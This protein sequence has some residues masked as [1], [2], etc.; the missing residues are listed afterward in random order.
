MPP[1]EQQF[2]EFLLSLDQV[3]KQLAEFMLGQYLAHDFSGDSEDDEATLNPQV[4]LDV[5]DGVPRVT[6]NHTIT[7]MDLTLDQEPNE[8]RLAVVLAFTG[9]GIAVEAFVRIDLER[10]MGEWPTGV[11]T[12]YRQYADG[13]GLDGA[14]A[15]VQARIEEMCRRHDDATRLGLA[16]R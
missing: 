16:R 3:Q 2:A 15:F 6:L 10:E 14:L 13:L 5:V 9:A 7:W 8:Y 11:H 1:V 4:L 12:P